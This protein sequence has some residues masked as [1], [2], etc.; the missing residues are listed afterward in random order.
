MRVR[1]AKLDRLRDS[2]VDPFPVGFPRTSTTGDIREQ[3]ADLPPDSA[4]G[5]RVGIAG[6]VVLNRPG[7]KLCFATL[8]DGT[9]DLQVMLSLDKVGQDG[10]D[11][12]KADVDLGDHVG[13]EGEVI[14]SKRGELSV[15]ADHWVLTSKALRPLPEKWKGLQDPEARV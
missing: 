1:R 11:A 8:R 12:W 15:L 7:G 10:L 3:Y 9:G 6:R 2:G 5:D 14:T 4:S 13:V